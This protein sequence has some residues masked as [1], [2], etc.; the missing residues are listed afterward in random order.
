M[1]SGGME[2]VKA[3][4]ELQVYKCTIYAYAVHISNALGYYLNSK[5]REHL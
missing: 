3:T 1:G 2:G 5:R 4:A